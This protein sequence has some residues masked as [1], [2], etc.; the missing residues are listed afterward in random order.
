MIKRVRR[1]SKHGSGI[2]ITTLGCIYWIYSDRV[3][4]I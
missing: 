3:V 2:I 4:V 1:T